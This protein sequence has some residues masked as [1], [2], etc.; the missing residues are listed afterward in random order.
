MYHFLEKNRIGVR[1]LGYRVTLSTT[2]GMKILK[3]RGYVN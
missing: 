2:S 3:E 1:P